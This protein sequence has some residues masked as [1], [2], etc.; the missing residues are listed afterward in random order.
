M[1]RK[2][3][4]IVSVLSFVVA[5]VSSTASTSITTGE[6]RSKIT[7][8]EKKIDANLTYIQANSRKCEENRRDMEDKLDKYSRLQMDQYDKVNKKI[9]DLMFTLGRMAGTVE[10]IKEK[11]IK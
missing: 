9:D 6:Y 8:Q 5:L 10:Y 2:L 1:D 11:G 7:N 3:G 4:V